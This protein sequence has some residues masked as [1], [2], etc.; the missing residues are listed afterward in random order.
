VR[1][2]VPFASSLRWSGVVTEHG[3]W[4]LGAPDALAPHL[5]GDPLDQ[6]VAGRAALGLRVLVLARATDPDA[7]L[8]DDT[9]RPAL[10][11]LR[12]VA[13]VALADE[14]RPEV[15]ET[16]ARFHAD[17]VAIKVLS[18][19]DPRTV[20]ALATQAGLD[21]GDPVA[22][23][24]L[25][26]LD[27]PALDRVV[28]RTTVFGRVA[29]EQKERIVAA[30]RRHGHYVA[31]IGDGVNDARALKGAHIGVAMRSGRRTARTRTCWAT[32]PGSSSPPRC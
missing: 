32:W 13:V 16:I 23:P 17:G 21:A 22:G 4:V 12:P 5:T 28:A 11:T 1:D 2:E 15:A 14:L 10:P 3:A 30:L 9:G 20:A 7:G 27:D 18:G 6:A 24:S 19:D 31:M 26:D 29:P 8:R 25:D